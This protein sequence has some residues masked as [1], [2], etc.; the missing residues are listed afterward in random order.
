MKFNAR[1]YN[2]A[3]LEEKPGGSSTA[4]AGKGSRSGEISSVTVGI[5]KAVFVVRSIT[6][7]KMNASI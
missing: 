6:R 4:S 7:K 2:M 3:T 1:G 5:P